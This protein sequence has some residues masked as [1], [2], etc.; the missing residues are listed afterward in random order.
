MHDVRAAIATDKPLHG[1]LRIGVAHALN[2]VALTKP[3]GVLRQEFPALGLRL[4]TGWSRD[5]LERVRA[6]ALDAAVILLPAEDRLPAEVFG[7][8]V[9]RDR[10]VVAG[11]KR[12]AHLRRLR[13]LD[14][15]MWILNPEGCGARAMLRRTLLRGGVE[16]LVAVESY[17]YDLQLRLAGE[18]RGLTLAPERILQRSPVRARLKVFNIAGLH[19]PL[20]VW[21]VRRGSAGLERVLARLNDALG[22][23]LR[24]G[25][26]SS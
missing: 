11:S 22:V 18:G 21:S 6:G 10:L 8:V 12:Q 1:E 3:L 23:Q 5:L 24:T 13:D 25:S 7:T 14:G 20:N 17:N 4:S 2:E 16:L 19:F 26:K 15:A 9:G